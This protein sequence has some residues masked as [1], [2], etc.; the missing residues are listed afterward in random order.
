[1]SESLS[2]TDDSFFR[3]VREILA[4]ARRKA[5][6]NINFIMVEAYWRIGR[7][8]V[9]EEQGGQSKAACGRELIRELSKQLGLEFG[10]GFS[11]ANLKNFRQFYLTYPD[12]GK[13][14]ALRSELRRLAMNRIHFFWPEGPKYNSLKQLPRQNKLASSL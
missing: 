1:M 8:I 10:K 13:S 9:E 12:L 3:S 4:E 11:V 7:R 5:A 2:T 6:S 14:Y